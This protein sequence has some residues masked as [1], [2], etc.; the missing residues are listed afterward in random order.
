MLREVIHTMVHKTNAHRGIIWVKNGEQELQPV[1]SAGINIEDVPAQ[2]EITDLRDVFNQILKRQQ[3]VLRHKDDDDFLQYCPVLTGKEESVLIV[4]VTN[5]AII[6]L[7]YAGRVIAD[8]PLANLLVGLSK[9]LSVAMEACTAHKNIIKEIQER[10]EAEEELKKKTE[11][12]ISSEKELQGLYGESEQARKLLMSILEDVTQKENAL[13][14][15]EEKYRNIIENIQDIFYRADMKGNLVMISLAGAKQMGYDSV[16]AMLGLNIAKTFYVVPEER[17]GFLKVLE[18]TG[19]VN[20]YE[21]TLKRKD[22]T[23]VPV[24]ASSHIYFDKSG[25]PLGVEG[26]LSDLTERKRAE[27]EI[28]NLQR[29]SRGLIESNLDPLVTFDSDG[30]IMDV[31]GATIQATGRTREELVGTPFADYFTDPERAYKG[32]MLAFEVGEVRDYEMVMK[33]SDGTETIV[34]YNA[35]LYKDPAGKVA[36]VFAAAR[37]ITERRAAED[38]I[39]KKTEELK[40]F[41]KLAVGREL[42]MIELKKEI[43]TL[44]EKLG[45]EPGY[46]IAGAL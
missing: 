38:E 45:E 34:S 9:K 11:Q 41:N 14:E 17:D 43:N 21:I 24:R 4:P 20:D 40:G 44:L 15:S 29:Y 19:V 1:A 10:V 31:N 6:H 32:A 28:E 18:K 25:N 42:K 16:D 33:A 2:G 7:V 8:E 5:V 13:R 30:V 36:G 39:K 27:Q 3:F 22:G 46:E 37:D 26:L 12:L 23:L 35:H